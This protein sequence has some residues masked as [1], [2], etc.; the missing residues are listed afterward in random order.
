MQ[1]AMSRL[2]I[3]TSNISEGAI[4]DA[5]AVIQDHS[6]DNP[7]SN[8]DG[9]IIRFTIK[10]VSSSESVVLFHGLGYTPNIAFSMG[11]VGQD[12]VGT[13]FTAVVDGLDTNART[14]KVVVS[15]P[16][17]ADLIMYVG[18]DRKRKTK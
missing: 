8:L 14:I 3:N 10:T 15:D 6:D 12:Y 2:D 13:T 16:C 7:F 4:V 11:V 17:E 1:V 5:F 9:K 18:R